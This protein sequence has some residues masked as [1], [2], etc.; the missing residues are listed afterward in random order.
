MMLGHAESGMH[1]AAGEF[2]GRDLVRADSDAFVLCEVPL[3]HKGI[4]DEPKNVEYALGRLLQAR[5]SIGEW[6][7][8]SLAEFGLSRFPVGY[9]VID[10]GPNGW[11]DPHV[12]PDLAIWSRSRL[13]AHEQLVSQVRLSLLAIQDNITPL[14]VD[15][16][17]RLRQLLEDTLLNLLRPMGVIEITHAHPVDAAKRA[18]YKAMGVPYKEFRASDI[19]SRKYPIRNPFTGDM[20][21]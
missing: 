6:S 18:K 2:F 7:G 9:R 15:M 10:L 4:M 20:N 17:L 16:D 14:T 5:G 3:T 1:K 8:D 13:Q 11:H 21:A 12:I 19:L